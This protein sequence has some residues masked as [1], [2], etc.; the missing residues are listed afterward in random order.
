[1]NTDEDRDYDNDDGAGATRRR[2]TEQDSVG[3]TNMI[4]MMHRMSQE[5]AEM[6]IQERCRFQYMRGARGGR[7]GGRRVCARRALMMDAA[8]ATPDARPHA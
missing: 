7:R 2:G 3:I 4:T 1:M 6:A 5:G 8:A